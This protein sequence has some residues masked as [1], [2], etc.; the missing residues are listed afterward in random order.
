MQ[1][2]TPPKFEL[3]PEQMAQ[4]TTQIRKQVLQELQSEQARKDEETKARREQEYEKVSSYTDTMKYSPDPWV[5]VRQIVDMK[6]GQ[7]KIEM[8]WNDA[9]IKECRAQG[10]SGTTEEDVIRKYLAILTHN[11]DQQIMDESNTETEFE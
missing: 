5:D 6:T 8:D 9:F 1:D 7:I 4:L 2:N 11:L 3:S 10:L